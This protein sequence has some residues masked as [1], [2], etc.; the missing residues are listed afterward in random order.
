MLIRNLIVDGVIEHILLDLN[1][2]YKNM[3]VETLKSEL[4]DK[5]EYADEQQ[6]QELYGLIINYFNGQGSEEQ[7]DLLS[8]DQITL[9]NNTMYY[10]S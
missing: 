10:I 5:I 9:I 7:W 8:E 3:E 6:L 4:H 2:I 1:I